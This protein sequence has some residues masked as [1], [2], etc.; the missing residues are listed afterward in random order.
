MSQMGLMLRSFQSITLN[1]TVPHLKI[2]LS[3]FHIMYVENFEKDW[4]AVNEML[5]DK[6]GINN[7]YCNDISWLDGMKQRPSNKYFVANNVTTF[8]EEEEN[9]IYSKF[10]CDFVAFGYMKTFL[11]NVDLIPISTTNS[12]YKYLRDILVE[13]TITCLRINGLLKQFNISE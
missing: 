4:L 12:S 5:C 10:Q 2:W 8:T 7:N 1:A 3:N 9:N 13:D 6:Y 11:G